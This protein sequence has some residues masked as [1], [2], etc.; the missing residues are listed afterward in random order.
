M[1]AKG[2]NGR[3]GVKER[4]RGDKQ[5][6]IKEIIVLEVKNRKKEEGKGTLRGKERKGKEYKGEYKK[7]Q[8]AK[9]SNKSNSR[10]LKYF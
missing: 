2:K 6:K 4:V 7:G 10:K 1:T 8:E 3:D 5:T 9:K